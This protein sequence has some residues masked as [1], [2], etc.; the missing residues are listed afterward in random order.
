[1]NNQVNLA[2]FEGKVFFNFTHKI[3]YLLWLITSN[4]FFL[5]NI[6]YPNYL[7]VLILQVYG[8]KI[9]KGIVIKPWVKIKFPW[10]LTI[11]NNVWI[12]E[13]VWID[14]ISHVKIASNVCIS[15]GALLITGNHNYN[16]VSFDLI[17]KPI[18]IEDGSWLCTNS[19]VTGGVTVNSHAVLSISSVATKDLSAFTVY[20]GNP[21]I[22]VKKRKIL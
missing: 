1:M 7:K 4:I 9:G 18:I 20:K 3:K 14:N 8:S 13:S 11:G 16:L 15:Q 12:G 17:S 21:A 19:V 2:K 22:E 5:T 6:P 10:E